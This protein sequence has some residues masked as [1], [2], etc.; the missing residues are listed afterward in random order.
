MLIYVTG[1]MIW[2]LGVSWDNQPLNMLKFMLGVDNSL[3]DL[4]E[5]AVVV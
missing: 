5:E 4:T 1:V 3:V 2:P